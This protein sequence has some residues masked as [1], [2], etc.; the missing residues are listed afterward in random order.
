ME[1]IVVILH[2]LFPGETYWEE[3]ARMPV[4]SFKDCRIVQRELLRTLT[5]FDGLPF[6]T[7][8]ADENAASTSTTWMRTIK[9]PDE[10]T[11]T[12]TKK[13]ARK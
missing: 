6:I 12:T 10:V 1:K 2:V 13:G 7:Q 4:A 8:C 9:E 3:A 5:A 11:T